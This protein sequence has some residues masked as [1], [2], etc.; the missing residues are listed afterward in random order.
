MEVYNLTPNTISFIYLILG[1]IAETI[2]T[3][4][5]LYT[6]EFSRLWPSIGVLILYIAGLFFLTLSTRVLPIGIAYA[7]WGGLGV[8]FVALFGYFL[9]NQKLDVYALLG[10]G[11]ILIGILIINLFSKSINH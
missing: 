4:C 1:I 2:A 8:V 6:K 3:S 9:Q 11:F 10:I 7:I 5:L